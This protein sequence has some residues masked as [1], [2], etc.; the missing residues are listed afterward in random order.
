MEVSFVSNSWWDLASDLQNGQLPGKSA[1][2]ALEASSG[3]GEPKASAASHP[4]RW[5]LGIKH[6]SANQQTHQ[7]ES[8]IAVK[9]GLPHDT[10]DLECWK[11]WNRLQ[12]EATE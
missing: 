10:L 11:R 7:S 1:T 4:L 2:G 9:D 3:G 5:I 8:S 12:S 6:K